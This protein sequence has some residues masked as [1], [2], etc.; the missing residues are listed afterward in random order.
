VPGAEGRP[1]TGNTVTT[2]AASGTCTPSANGTCLT[3]VS[4]NCPAGTAVIGCGSALSQVCSDGSNGIS[5]TFINQN[6]GCTVRSFNNVA[7]GLCPTIT[8]NV[9]AQARCINTP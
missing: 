8:F 4:A 2:V 1:G 9:L 7:H 5:D 6:N 3:T